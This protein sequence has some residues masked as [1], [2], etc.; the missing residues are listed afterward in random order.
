MCVYVD[1]CDA[2]MTRVSTTTAQQRVMHRFDVH[3]PSAAARWFTRATSQTTTAGSKLATSLSLSLSR[4][5]TH[6]YML[7]PQQVDSSRTHARTRERATSNNTLQRRRHLKRAV[8]CDRSIR[9]LPF[10]RQAH[11][12][13]IALS[14]SQLTNGALSTC[15]SSL[16]LLSLAFILSIDRGGAWLGRWQGPRAT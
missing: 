9:F 2:F 14:P 16:L 13:S 3:A 15:L 5:C 1:V 10:F 7:E 12:R 8:A 11:G 4:C 6:T